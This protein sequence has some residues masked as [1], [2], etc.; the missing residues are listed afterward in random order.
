[1]GVSAVAIVA[2]AVPAVAQ[3]QPSYSFNQPAQKLGDMLRAIGARTSVNIAFD[4]AVVRGKSSPPVTGEMSVRDALERA[5]AGSGLSLHASGGGYIV[6]AASTMSSMASPTESE[7]ATGEQNEIVVTAQKRI[8]RLIETPQS[9]ASISAADLGRLNATQFTDF[10]DTVPGLQFTTQG[11]GTAQISLRGVT[12]G[13]DVGPTVAIYVDEVPYGSSSSFA[14]GVRRALD[15]GLFDLER[16]EVLRGPQGTLYGASAMGG[17]LKYVMR[18]PSLTDAGGSAQLGVSD[19]RRGGTSYDGSGVVNLPL[20]EDKLAARASGYYARSGGYVDNVAT[21]QSDVD[22]G[23][24]YGGRLDLYAKPSED[25]TVRVTGFAQNIRRDGGSYSSIALTGAPVA[26]PLDQSHPL[27]E[28]FR[29]NFRLVSGTIGYEFGGATLTSVSSYQSAKAYTTTD[30][31]AVYAPLLNLFFGIP[32]Q[33]VGVD[34]LARTRKFT[35]EL[36]LASEAGSPLEWLVGGFYTR[37]KSLLHQ[38]GTAY[39][40]G[41]TILPVNIVDASIRSSYR[42]YALFGDLTYH[43]TD[44]FDVTGGVRYAHN[45]QA[46]QQDASGLLVAPGPR[47]TSGEGVTTYLANARYRF[48]SHMTAYARFATG[49]RPGGPNYLAID[50]ST[51]TAVAPATFGSDSLDSYEVGFKAE[52]PDRRF[53]IDLSAFYIDWK[54]IQLLT[55]VAGVTTYLN[56]GGA[57]IKGGE[58]TLTAR[59]GRGWLMTGAFAYN[60]GYITDDNAALGAR[61]GER[62]PNTPHVTASVNADYRMVDSPLQPRL[63]ATL[64]YVSDRSASFDAN[65]SLPQYDLPDYVA[66]DLRAGLSVGPVD[67]QFYVKNLFDVRGQLS[68]QTILSGFGGP[69]QVTIMQPRTIG[70]KLT[71]DF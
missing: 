41:L 38:V 59:P 3:A 17:V 25:L 58:L 57:H 66:V 7:A 54:N 71:T 23:R 13:A 16:I 9:V 29:A 26:G 62:L 37:E 64:R 61:S 48:T 53:G 11:A 18:T 49:Y 46:F 36:R 6:S 44:K 24:I 50:P 52:T 5:L 22:R 30:G 1:M 4:P 42:E 67:A 70:L 12:T 63:G 21:G 32:A 56:A 33:A 14:N 27:E 55:A 69:A 60:D 28:P 47:R 65:G 45:K 35:Q 43:L 2:S 20:V 68:A 40:A 19:I 34:E 15:V 51:G 31:S 10:A 8:E 39:G